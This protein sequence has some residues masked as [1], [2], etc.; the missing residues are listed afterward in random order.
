GAPPRPWE[1]PVEYAQRAGGAT[2]IEPGTLTTLAA[3]TTA[4]G[5]GPDGVDDDVARQAAES[6]TS[7]ERGVRERLDRRA[8]LR[9]ALDPRGLLPDRRAR[10]DVRSEAGARW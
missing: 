6:A 4:A 7:V 1:T 3:V 5:Y 8:R 2:G 10:L 9:R